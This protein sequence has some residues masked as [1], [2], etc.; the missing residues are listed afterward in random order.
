MTL[1]VS[2]YQVF[3]VHISFRL[4]RVVRRR[5]TLPFHQVLK[6]TLPSVTSVVD[7]GFD[8]I[9]LFIPDQVGWR[10]CEVGSVGDSF[11]VRQEERDVEHV[12]DPPRQGK[13]E[14]VCH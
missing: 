6:L 2:L 10:S 9:L 11:S 4:P 1:M 7:D 14:L 8:L 12:V 5:I 3:G 13:S